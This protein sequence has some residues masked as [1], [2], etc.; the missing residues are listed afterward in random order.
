M[1]FLYP[2]WSA[3]LEYIP[4]VCSIMSNA[5][6]NMLLLIIRYNT[7]LSQLASVM[8]PPLLYIYR[9]LVTRARDL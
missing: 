7:L 4:T 2:R 9:V 3:I 8:L 5:I 1:V 6:L